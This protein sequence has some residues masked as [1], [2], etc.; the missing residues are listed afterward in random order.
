MAKKEPKK[1]H[2]E[3]PNEKCDYLI[4]VKEEYLEEESF[5]EQINQIKCPKCGSNGFKKVS[6]KKEIEIKKK[7]EAEKK[8]KE[9][10]R[11]NEVKA[12]ITNEIKKTLK[13][14]LYLLEKKKIT[15]EEF[16]AS[17]YNISFDI[18]FSK[19]ENIN[20]DFLREKERISKL[21]DPI[22]SAHKLEEDLD[23]IIVNYDI[24]QTKLYRAYNLKYI[25]GDDSLYEEFKTENEDFGIIKSKKSDELKEIEEIE[26]DDIERK[27]VEQLIKELATDTE[28]Q[29]REN[30][31]QMN[32]KN[33]ETK[34]DIEENS[35]D[36]IK[37]LQK[38][39]KK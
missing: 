39:L 5:K 24:K 34:R 25:Y 6:E 33:S 8:K 32:R 30:E 19:K 37:K 13:E 36:F 27:E 16:I 4:T 20:P 12:E 35:N 38:N 3:C 28:I 11:V 14:L 2:F 9:E 1:V 15:P 7:I 31:S 22:I 10:K 23:T 29:K 26:K 18:I 21:C 17:F